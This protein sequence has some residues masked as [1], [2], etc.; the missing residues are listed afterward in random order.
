MK[1]QLII[2]AREREKRW[3]YSEGNKIMRYEVHQPDKQS[4]VGNVY[5]G[6]VESIKPSLNA[7]FVSFDNGRNGYL[8]LKEIPWAK[9]TDTIAA[10]IH[11]GKRIMVQV[12]KDESHSKGAVLSAN[13]EITGTCFVYFP[14]GQIVTVSKKIAQP[15]ER[16]RL[17]DWVKNQLAENEGLIIRTEASLQSED[18]LAEDLINLKAAIA[19]WEKKFAAASQS[20]FPIY[21]RSSFAASIEH[22]MINEKAGSLLIDSK[23]VLS[24]IEQ[25][26]NLNKNL[27][28]SCELV[29][30]DNNIFNEWG[31]AAAEEKLLKK[32]VWLDGGISI[33]IEKTEALTVIDVNSGKLAKSSSEK[34]MIRKINERA[35]SEILYQLQLRDI[36]GIVIIDFINMNDQGDRLAVTKVIQKRAAQDFK[37]IEVIGF[38]ELSLFQLTRK[39]TRPSFEEGRLIRCPVCSGKGSVLSPESLAFQL[40]RELIENRRTIDKRV[41]VH[42]TRDVIH[43][44]NGKEQSFSKE[45]EQILGFEINWNERKHTHP[46]Y[47]LSRYE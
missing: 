7:A 14:Y 36:S 25:F 37:H 33:V 20:T 42:A 46:F 44:F 11:Q 30:S 43:A 28:W 39:K 10:V 15:N 13:I 12:N 31:L 32:V 40:E 45:L 16:K 17:S 3:I 21:E 24:H 2:N 18:Q 27:N 23:E 6:V 9:K 19:G 41:Q 34:E 22:I 5:S 1:K 35:A 47:E 38:T 26:L 4:K 8:S 29:L